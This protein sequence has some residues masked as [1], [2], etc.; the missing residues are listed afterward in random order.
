MCVVLPDGSVEVR[1]VT[2]VVG[3]VITLASALSQTPNANSM[4]LL[5]VQH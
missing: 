2:G 3:D 1:D 4:W 5:S